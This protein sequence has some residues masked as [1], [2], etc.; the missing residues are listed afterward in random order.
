MTAGNRFVPALLIVAAGMFAAA[1]FIIDTAPYESTMGLVQRIFYF[2]VPN[3]VLMMVVSSACGVASAMYI[4][5]RRPVADYVALAT[6]ELA[7]VLGAIVL[8]TGPLWARKSWGVWWDW[9]PRLTSTLIMWLVF[10]SYLLLRR[11]GGAGSELLAAAVGIFGAVLTPFVY[12]SVNLWRTLHPKTSVLPTL[13]GPMAVPVIWCFV[14]FI[15]LYVAVILLR[16]RLE[17][18]RVTLERA[19]MLLEEV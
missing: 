5:R 12:W 11:F 6:A 14:A 18:T 13:P 7:V 4:A 2:H 19:W 8:L 15:L 17:S 9:E 16:I 3:A 1:P 10:S